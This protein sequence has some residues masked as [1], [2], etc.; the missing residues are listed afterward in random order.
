M[1][2]YV[3]IEDIGKIY[4]KELSIHY[5]FSMIEL[6]E[7][8]FTIATFVAEKVYLC[9]VD[10]LE[11]KVTANFL[12]Q[13]SLKVKN[14]IAIIRLSQKVKIKEINVDYIN[15][16]FSP[17]FDYPIIY[18]SSNS[19]KKQYLDKSLFLASLIKYFPN[20]L[21]TLYYKV[22]QNKIIFKNKLLRAWVDVDEELHKQTI[23]DSTIFIYPFGI[24]IH[25]G[26]R[27]IKHCFLKYDSVTLMGVP[28]SFFLL[29]KAFFLLLFSNTDLGFV[30][31]EI[32]A[33]QKHSLLFRKF[34]EIYTSDEFSP[35]VLALYDSLAANINI[36]NNCH[37]VG[38]YNLYINYSSMDV[39]TSSQK[40]FYQYR[41]PR[42]IFNIKE[43]SMEP[44]FS[45]SKTQKIIDRKIIYIEQGNYKMFKKYNLLYEY[46]LQEKTLEKLNELSSIIGYDIY[47]KFH[48]NR[49]EKTKKDLLKNFNNIKLIEKPVFQTGKE[50][51]F[52]NLFST[53]YYDFRIY[54]KVIF[55]KDDFFNP[56]TIFGDNIYTTTIIDLEQS[57]LAI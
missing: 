55:I 15:K 14:I 54:G 35:P 37:G 49:S 7:L 43:T 34:Q 6:D 16:D 38:T 44:N 10:S 24:N 57:L 51:I 36:F 52:I 1:A 20:K 31:Y 53:A 41:N 39:F 30:I 3:I 40:N 27:F 46:D 33:M 47:V 21:F 11:Y 19:S 12:A 42:V 48:P 9:S 29:I 17:F 4:T 2:D 18:I 32:K 56:N 8:K 13:R 26:F 23:N 50:H 45:F 5:P 22:F 25:R 28:Y